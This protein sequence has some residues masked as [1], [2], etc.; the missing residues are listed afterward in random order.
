M[1]TPSKA[2]QEQIDRLMSDIKWYE[3][4]R[5]GGFALGPNANFIPYLKRLREL[6]GD[7]LAKLGH[8]EP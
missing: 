6:T 3:G 2:E 5:D 1:A 8:P 4:L 7:L